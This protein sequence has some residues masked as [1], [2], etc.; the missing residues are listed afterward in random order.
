VV[1]LNIRNISEILLTV[2]VIISI[3]GTVLAQMGDVSMG[4]GKGPWSASDMMQE[5]K[6]LRHG[7]GMQGMGFMHSGGNMFGHYVTFTVNESTGG[8]EQYA[9]DGNAIFDS[10][11]LDEFDFGETQVMGTMTR[12]T[13]TERN[14][15]IQVHDNAAAVINFISSDT[16]IA[17]FDLADGVEAARDNGMVMIKSADV[18]AYLVYGN[19]SFDVSIIDGM[20]SITAPKDSALVMRA[21][22]VNMPALGNM[23]KMLIQEMARNRVGAEVCFGLNDSFDVVNYSQQMR[24]HMELMNSE[25]IRMRVNSTD[26]EGKILSFNLD[27]TSL[28]LQE[29]ERLRIHYDGIPITCINDPEQVLYTS[30]LACWISQQ[31]RERAQIMIHVPE[32]SEH[33]IEIVVEAESGM[34]PTEAVT[35]MPTESASKVPGYEAVIAISGLLLVVYLIRR[36]K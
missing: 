9:I 11:T 32:F 15:I 19:G 30:D 25:R 36:I 33:V 8:I 14:T 23:N 34:E 12:I 10:I 5:G 27:N 17:N 7:A 24:I 16:Y 26:P 22:P 18:T 6:N 13:D 4:H 35:E 28:R 29:R 21:F 20:V 1:R 2:L 31:S 3:S